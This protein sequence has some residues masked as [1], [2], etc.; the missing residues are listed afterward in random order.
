MS[1]EHPTEQRRPM[2][3]AAL[4]GGTNTPQS[5][6]TTEKADHPTEGDKTTGRSNGPHCCHP[7]RPTPRSHTQRSPTSSAPH[8]QRTE[9]RWAKITLKCTNITR[10]NTQKSSLIS[11]IFS[12]F[13]LDN[14]PLRRGTA[15]TE[16]ISAYDKES[17]TRIRRCSSRNDGHR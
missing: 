5:M 6:Q 14:K 12:T 2:G 8:Q 10:K 16:Q 4:R 1:C 13:V 17:S 9:K 15:I 7:P 3:A 11:D